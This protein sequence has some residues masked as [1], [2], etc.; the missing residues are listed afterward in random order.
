MHTRRWNR[1][2]GSVLVALGLFAAGV[3]T[4]GPAAPAAN[5][6]PTQLALTA[7]PSTS[8]AGQA[9][10]LKATLSFTKFGNRVPTGLVH[11]AASN[12]NGFVYLGSASVGGCSL[13]T[14]KCT[15]TLVTT[16]LPTGHDA[17]GAIYTGNSYFKPSGGLTSATVTAAPAPGAPTLTSATAGDA[18]VALEWSAP[19]SGGPV[20]T[21]SVYRGTTQGVQGPLLISGLTGT[22]YTDSTAAN[23]STYYYVVTASNGSGE[24]PASNELSARPPSSSAT[25]CALGTACSSPTVTSSD[26]SSAL[27]V[28]SAPSTG[29]QTLTTQ[30]GGLPDMLCSLAGSGAVTAEYHTSA[31]DAGKVADYTVFGAVAT[32]AQNFYA[33]HTDI[34]G[35]YGAVD[36]WNGWSPAPPDCTECTGGTWADGP[37]VYGPVPFDSDTGLFEGF[38]GNCANHSGYQPCFTN[39]AGD[40]SNDTQVHSP[41]GPNDPRITH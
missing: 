21:Y 25:T 18:Q 36:Q 40:G 19:T 23:D 17:V 10:T 6:A 27:D 37:Y 2:T 3:A 1:R 5:R 28:T 29:S 15:A 16:N 8:S 11:Y 26:G 13:V 31:S 7:T 41:A 35:C 30:V 39:I 33:A 12:G 22:T 32:F 20:S 14:R 9:V 4:A 38:L 34:S 24:S